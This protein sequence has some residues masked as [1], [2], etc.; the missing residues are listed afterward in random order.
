MKY[1]I[2]FTYATAKVT[3]SGAVTGSDGG[4]TYEINAD[5]TKQELEQLEIDLK[6]IAYEVIKAHKVKGN[7]ID[8]KITG[9]TALVEDQQLKQY[10]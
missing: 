5:I 4:G 2:S 7:V 3:K 10:L 1:E 9:I 6:A 8:I